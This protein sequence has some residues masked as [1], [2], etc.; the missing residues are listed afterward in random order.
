MTA[1][2]LEKPSS[3]LIPLTVSICFWKNSVPSAL[4]FHSSN[5]AWKLQAI[6]D[7]VD[8]KIIAAQFAEINTK[9]ATIPGVGTTLGATILSEI[10]DINRFEKPK[11]VINFLTPFLPFSKLV[12]NIK[13]FILLK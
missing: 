12:K 3:F 7:S 9:L 10:G 4:N 6:T 5:S 13:L 1:N 2:L 11:H 8:S